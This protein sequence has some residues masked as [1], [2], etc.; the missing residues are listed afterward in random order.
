MQNKPNLGTTL[1]IIYLALVSVSLA[2]YH[3]IIRFI[4]N[5][6]QQ[7]I[8]VNLLGWSATIFATIALLYTFN[9]W[10]YQKRS[11]EIAKLSRET[12]VKLK[13][14]DHLFLE[15][16]QHIN[17]L[18]FFENYNVTLDDAKKINRYLNVDVNFNYEILK[19]KKHCHIPNA[20]KNIEKYINEYELIQIYVGQKIYKELGFQDVTP[21]PVN[22]SNIQDFMESYKNLTDS[23]F[24]ISI[25]DD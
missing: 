21:D 17:T 7:A 16:A 10:K 4:S 6:N 25:F 5:N 19:I 22:L 9:S 14:K 8:F 11:E 12:Y 13:E 2:I 20:I 1:A 23:L 18:N 24:E 3:L 15:I